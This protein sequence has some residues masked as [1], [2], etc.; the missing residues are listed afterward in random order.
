MKE[1]ITRLQQRMKL[2]SNIIPIYES[3]D[4]DS[5]DQFVYDLLQKLFEE[6]QLNI[7]QRNMKLAGFPGKKNA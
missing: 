7:M 1:A 3:I 5:K 4:Y 6:R 2:S